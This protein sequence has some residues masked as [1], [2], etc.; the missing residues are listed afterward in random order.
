MAPD[1]P[2]GA[3]QPG[4]VLAPVQAAAEWYNVAA[5]LKRR[6]VRLQVETPYPKD[7]MPIDGWQKLAKAADGWRF[8][9]EL[10]RT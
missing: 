10:I 2:H 5:T 7:I 3:R 8:K 6:A 4:C 9:A 1:A